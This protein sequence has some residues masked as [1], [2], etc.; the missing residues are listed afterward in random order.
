MYVFEYF[1]QPMREQDFC[2]Y[3]CENRQSGWMDEWEGGWKGR[4]KDGWMDRQTQAN[5]KKT[6]KRK[7]P[8][9][10]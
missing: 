2:V 6:T 10:F 8:Y 9:A 5:R 1:M 4:W 3:K 7:V